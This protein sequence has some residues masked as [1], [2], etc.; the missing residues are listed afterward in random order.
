MPRTTFKS[1]VEAGLP[2][3]NHRAARLGVPLL[4][5][6]VSLAGLFT[7]G[8]GWA[9]PL[10]TSAGTVQ[11][12]I[13]ADGLNEPWAI[14]FLPDGS[15]LI[16]ERAGR[17]L[18]LDDGRLSEISGLP[19][20]AVDGQGGLLDIL[21]P[22]D[23]TETRDLYFSYSKPQ[24]SGAGTALLRARLS[25]DG[26]SLEQVQTI[27]ELTP[28]SSGGVHFGARIVEAPDGKLFMTIGERG[29]QPS[30]QDLRRENGSVIRVARDGSIPADNPFV[31]QPDAK[32]A[33][34]SYGHRNPQ[35][36]AL[37]LQGN[38]ITVEHGAQGG[39]EVNRIKSGANY[40]WPLISYGVHYGGAPIG[41]GTRAPGLEQPA[42]FWDP[43]IAPSGMTVYSG[44]LWPDWTGDIF[45]GSLKFDYISRLDGEPLAEVEQLSSDDTARVRD[46]RE[47]PDGSLWF[48]S[49]GN[50]ALYRMSP[51]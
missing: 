51:G 32:P 21:V 27:F 6:G 49:V 25:L 10:E 48:L 9:G 12:D 40:G 20:M 47:A 37:D 16:T 30:A 23:F 41:I 45:V 50:G 2:A 35:G 3:H 44:K 46:L 14:G 26:T 31:T 15:V 1:D 24:Q 8:A 7:T 28:G 29:D 42:F 18:R 11:V 36:A 34:W 17:L 33:I 43:S 5:L 39:D 19:A 13:V 38:L 22:R 4:A